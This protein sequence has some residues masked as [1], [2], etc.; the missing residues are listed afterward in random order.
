[1]GLPASAAETRPLARV[2]FNL[3]TSFP[4]IDRHLEARGP[5]SPLALGS[6]LPAR[7]LPAA[8][9]IGG[10]IGRISN[11]QDKERAVDRTR[12]LSQFLQLYNHLA[13][14]AVVFLLPTPRDCK[15][16]DLVFTANIGAALEHLPD[17]NIVVL[18]S[19]TSRPGV[20]EARV[21]RAFFKSM[22]CEV[23]QAPYKFE[24]EAEL[25]H[26]YDNVYLG[27]YGIRSDRKVYE[28]MESE[29]DMKVIKL[30]EVDEYLYHLDCTVFPITDEDTLVCTEMF[31]K[32]ELKRVEKHT[33]I[34]DVSTD[35]AYSGICNSVRFHNGVLNASNIHSLRPGSD[36]Y[37]AEIK[38]NRELEDIA[39]R[40]GLEVNYFNLS[41]YMKGGALL[42]CMVMHLNRRSYAFRL[43]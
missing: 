28:W 41:E 35:A 39:V 6:L 38:K 24:G 7:A 40:L 31:T 19:F 34:I 12:A 16:Q 18:S 43:I 13:S 26:L 25:K 30:E 27:G 11:V 20:G 1:L 36:Q 23:V 4:K 33:N 32:R 5:P 14:D 42:S 3:D 15:L 29:F 10:P 37:M 8:P 22:G 21:G 9:R 2:A 17:E